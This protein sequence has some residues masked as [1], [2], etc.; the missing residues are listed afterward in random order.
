MINLRDLTPKDLLRLRKKKLEDDKKRQEELE[1]RRKERAQIKTYMRLKH[2]KAFSYYAISHKTAFYI[3]DDWMTALEIIG[4]LNSLPGA[5]CTC[6]KF[7][8]IKKAREHLERV[9]ID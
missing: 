6:K 5:A 3:T 4:E 8:S 9:Y 7:P 1:E 2:K